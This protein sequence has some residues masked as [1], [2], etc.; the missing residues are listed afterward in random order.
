[1]HFNLD[2]SNNCLILAVSELV[3]LFWLPGGKDSVYSLSLGMIVLWL[4]QTAQVKWYTY[5]KIST[6]STNKFVFLYTCQIKSIAINPSHQVFL[7]LSPFICLSKTRLLSSSTSYFS[8]LSSFHLSE[9]NAY[10]E[11][12]VKSQF[13][14]CMATCHS[15]TKIEGQLSGD[16]L[17]LKMFEATGW[18]SSKHNVG[19]GSTVGMG[20]VK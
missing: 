4:C 18:V 12:L 17:D 11:N 15:L 1:M 2:I 14:A 16:P 8:C 6:K 10:K 7:R 3:M 19:Q 20:S 5:Y 9:E 13:V